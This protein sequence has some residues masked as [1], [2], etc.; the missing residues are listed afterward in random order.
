MRRLSFLICIFIMVIQVPAQ[1]PHGAKLTID[2]SECHEPTAWKVEKDKI[3]FDH[4][5]TIFALA[6]QHQNVDCKKCHTPLVFSD[7]RTEC[8]SC[9][10]DIHKNSVGVDCQ[11]CH[12]PQ[13]WIVTNVLPIHQNTHFPLFGV[14]AQTECV[15]CHAEYG[16]L[17][18]R[19]AGVNCY[20]CHAANFTSTTSPSHVAAGFSRDCQ[21]CHKVT[22]TSWTQGTYASHSFFPLEQGHRV[23][24]FSCHRK[25]TFKGLSRECY[26]C[27]RQNYEA[28]KIPDHKKLNFATQCQGCHSI[29]GWKP[30]A[31]DHN[32]TGFVLAGAHRT[33][34]CAGCHSNGTANT[35]KVCDG[36]HLA[37]ISKPVNPNHKLANFPK[38]C[39]QCHNVNAWKPAS[40]N[41]AATNFP[42]TGQ[43]VAVTC[44]QCHTVQYAG[45]AKDCYSCHVNDNGIST[46]PKHNMG[47]F[48]KLCEQCHT[49]NGWKPTLFNHSMTSYPLTGKHQ[50]V[51]CNNCHTSVYAGTSVVCKNCHQA[52]ISKP[53]NPLHTLGNFPQSCEQCHSPS[54][55]IPS[56]FN[57]A[58]TNF[59]LV[60]RHITVPCNNCHVTQYSGTAKDCYQCHLTDYNGAQNPNHKSGGYPTDCSMCHTSIA[61]IPSSFNHASTG[62]TLTG[63]HATITCTDCH[64]TTIAHLDPTCSVC[65]KAD[66]ST[67]KVVNHN[68]GNF[69][70]GKTCDMCH[71]TAVWKPSSFTHAATTFPLTGIHAT[72]S[73]NSCHTSTYTGTAKDCYSCHASNYNSSVNP[74]HA[75][76]SLSSIF[77]TSCSNCHSTSGWRP[78]TWSH[79][80][81]YD[82]TVRHSAKLCSDCHTS[83]A[84]PAAPQ[85]ISCHQSDFNKEH[86]ASSR[87]DC[88]SSGCHTNPSTFNK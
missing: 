75:S 7:A 44:N 56:S 27:H 41:H 81:Y 19:T 24:C 83:W 73:C 37:D 60:G 52:D 36:C 15:S 42:L 69:L 23:E 71:S 26:A 35:P 12:T 6:G 14:H 22:A 38:V 61:W 32:T 53:V 39:D 76:S 62:F 65:H 79:K 78:T 16:I 54:G 86:N 34:D 25:D 88:W 48:P 66:I 50:T 59:Q 29:A 8:N 57:H 85:C 30:A 17:N 49:T 80:Q 5:K 43:H 2:C 87:K 9:H 67:S 40:F 31:F 1:S 33:V 3:K 21:E 20:D 70:T 46:N 18:F 11:R 72:T 82:I 51:L 13:S 74:P 64:G 45:T 58:S 77:V 4:A 28:T 55:W 68:L 47:N 84:N 10:K 63:K